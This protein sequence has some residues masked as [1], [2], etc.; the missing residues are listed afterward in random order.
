[1]H[2]AGATTKL[3]ELAGTP[4]G[5]GTGLV[6]PQ[7]AARVGEHV[8]KGTCHVCHDATGPGAATWP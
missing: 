7:S 6:V 5:E 1:M 2:H 8:V 3:R 4:P